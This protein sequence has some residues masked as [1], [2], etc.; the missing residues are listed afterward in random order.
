MDHEDGILLTRSPAGVYNLLAASLHLRIT[1]LH[2]R[3]IQI[4][5]DYAGGNRGGRSTAEPD[6]HGRTA[7]HND[8][9]ARGYRF[10][11]DVRF[12]NIAQSS[13]KHDGFVVAAQEAGL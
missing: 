11:L 7:E 10:F 8:Q 6:L 5:L 13:G 3:E 9:A 1:A 4:S 12:A 2:R